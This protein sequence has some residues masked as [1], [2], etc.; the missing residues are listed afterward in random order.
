MAQF[1]VNEEEADHQAQCFYLNSGVLMRKWWPKDV[2]AD[3]DW[4]VAHQIVLPRKY[5]GEI[6]SLAHVSPMAGHLGVN[7]T[8]S[9]I[10]NHFYWPH[11]RKDVSEFCKC[12]HVCQ[13]V[14]KPN[15][16]ILVTPLKPIPVCN[17]IFSHVIFEFVGPLPKTT[18]GNQYLLTIMCRF[19]RFL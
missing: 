15:Q 16:T 12:C 1:A 18:S 10:L 3:E 13:K 19:T 4:Q 6:L 5:Q 11:L 8:Y 14:G 17:E 2:P 7:K 9:K